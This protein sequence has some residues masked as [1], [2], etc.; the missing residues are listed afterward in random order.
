MMIDSETLIIKTGIIVMAAFSAIRLVLHELNAGKR[1]NLV[2]ASAD[3][4]AVRERYLLIVD[5]KLL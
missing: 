3:G 4:P 1:L 5:Q 2:G